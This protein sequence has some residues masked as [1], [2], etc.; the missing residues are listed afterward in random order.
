[1]QVKINGEPTEVQ[2]DL[3]QND[4]RPGDENLYMN[5]TRVVRVTHVLIDEIPVVLVLE[6][7]AVVEVERQTFYT[8]PGM[9]EDWQ[10]GA[11]PSSLGET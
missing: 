11:Q 4:P 10:P 1:M 8:L 7:D 6:N 9:N 5:G 3:R 2:M